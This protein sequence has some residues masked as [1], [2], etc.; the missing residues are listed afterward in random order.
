[1]A[2]EWIGE[3]IFDPDVARK[4]RTKHNLDPD[5]VQR[6][7]A[8]GAHRSARWHTDP[9]YGPRLIVIGTADGQTVRV[10][11]RPLDRS[12]G[13]WECATAWRIDG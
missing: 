2:A 12:D 13:R 5:T 3:I 10:L 11:L 1:M 6:A 7:V 9:M 8:R 4:L